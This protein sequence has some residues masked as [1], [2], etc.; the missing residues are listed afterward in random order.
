[1]NIKAFFDTQT[2]TL[3]YVVW[4]SD[5]R[6]AVVIDSVLNYDQASSTFDYQSVD[7]VANFVQEH[8]LTLHLIMETHA[9]ADHLTGAFE[10]KKRFPKAKIVIGEHITKVQDIFKKFFNLG[11]DMPTD[12]SQ[13]DLLAKEGEPVQAGSLQFQVLHTPGHTPACVSYVIDDAVFTG[14]ALFMPDFGV[15]RCDFP[16]GSAETLYHSVKEKI[17]SLPA[18]TKVYTGHD[19]QP[20]GRPLRYESTIAEEKDHNIHINSRTTQ[21]HF[22]RFRSERDKGLSAPQRL[23]PSVQVNI[24]AGQFPSPENNG[25][26]YLKIPLRPGKGVK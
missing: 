16:G 5:S 4:D 23:L 21:E 7:E 15:A 17:Y 1:M 3:S 24:R 20:G 2:S 25:V 8:K 12:A 22:V 19:Y 6:D 26:S 13:F 14:D 11:D 10:L 9:H 18:T